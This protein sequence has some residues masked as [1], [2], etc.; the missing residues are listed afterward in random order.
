MPAYEFPA[1]KPAHEEVYRK[2]AT[3]QSAFLALS[4]HDGDLL[5]AGTHPIKY[6]TQA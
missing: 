3:G 1:F 2:G 6:G 4:R 5:D